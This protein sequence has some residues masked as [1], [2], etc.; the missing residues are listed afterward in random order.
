MV[1]APGEK[2]QYTV[3]NLYQRW[4]N[5]PLKQISWIQ[6]HSPYY[7]LST[8]VTETNCILPWYTTK[9]SKGLNTLPDYRTMSA[10]FWTTQ[11]QHNSAGGHQW[12][13]YTDVNNV[14]STS[15]TTGV[16]IDSYGPTYA[17]IA[18][19]F[20]TSDGKVELTYTHMEMPQTDENRS[21]YEMK[22]TIKEDL[23]I[24]DFKNQFTFYSVTDNCPD[25]GPSGDGK[26]VYEKVGYLDENNKYQVADAADGS[27]LKTYVL[28]KECPY[29]S[30][31]MMPNYYR[32][33][34]H[35][36]GYSNVAVLIY[37]YE[38]IINGEE[39][40]TNF[41]LRN[42]SNTVYLSLNLDDVTFKAGDTI[43]INAIFMPWGSQEYE[44]GIVDLT[45]T[46]PNYEYDMVVGED[47]NGDSIYYMDKNV[48]DVRENTL[49]D[50]L[51]ATA[52]KDC[53]VLNSV[54]V[55]KVK[56]TNGKTAEFT[57]SGGHNN[58]TVRV[59]GFNM[60]TVPFIEEYVDGEWKEYVVSSKDTA[61]A[62]GFYHY[63]DGYMVNYDGD[64]TYSY[65]FVVPM[66][67]G[68]PRKFRISATKEFE[69]WPAINDGTSE[70]VDDPINYFL[71]PQEIMLNS[72]SSTN[73]ASA[74]MA[75]DKSSVSLF[76]HASVAET[77]F[78]FKN[79]ATDPQVTGQYVVVKYKVPTGMNNI[80]QFEFF[81]TTDLSYTSAT[82]DHRVQVSATTDNKWHML[83]INLADMCNEGV[84]VPNGKGEY[85]A[86]FIRWDFLNQKVSA[87][88]NLDIAYFG[89]HDN[90]DDIYAM[91]LNKE[92]VP[93]ETP[94]Y[95]ELV[96]GG[97]T[98]KVDPTTGE[99]YI[100]TYVHKD[101]GYTVS[102]VEYA[103]WID[104][105]N[106]E[107]SSGSA[108]NAKAVLE[109]S[110]PGG[111]TMSDTKNLVL[112]G[113]AVADGGIEKYVWSADG[114]K[115]WHDVGLYNTTAISPASDAYFNAYGSIKSYTDPITGEKVVPAVADKEA[116]K[117]N[118]G[119][120][121]K[122]GIVA[123]LSEYSSEVVNVTFA[124]VP[125]ADTDSLCIIVHVTGVSVPEN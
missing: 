18:L 35:A 41:Y 88:M 115:T 39:V 107:S 52:D 27:D 121:G 108:H 66:D 53:E 8:G 113:W 24:N 15:E 17:D 13:R 117:A 10:P 109:M 38:V 19:D 69:G 61:D 92:I 68:A 51:K 54:F 34:P 4:G 2:A 104:F 58:S 94:K 64:G 110:C 40:D 83:I 111:T 12:L 74:E 87:D 32:E 116:S 97:R 67:H 30:F 101:S 86:S 16:R 81:T 9:N 122:G 21:Y 77:Y 60:L 36:E 44:D 120:Q 63:Y 119:F 100:P 102:D 118:S 55:P 96:E 6:F 46:P 70:I 28:G 56:T 31:F 62:Y 124:A 72:V 85:A 76:G 98:V 93:T 14:Y 26:S 112:T 48:R 73:I 5:Y 106:R 45:T 114:G 43:T 99:E 20:V 47:E 57:V 80:S 65:S 50:P 11:P 125:K 89:V 78:F 22:Y 95:I 29:F 25:N 7:H 3:L 82:G 49:L 123:D 23:S 105:I 1:V 59:Y 75:P 79:N 37:N 91:E 103:A 84:F 33:N 42:K 71:Q 90:L